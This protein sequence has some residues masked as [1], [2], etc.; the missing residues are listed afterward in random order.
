[1][2]TTIK[3]A[4]LTPT[5]KQKIQSIRDFLNQLPAHWPLGSVVRLLTGSDAVKGAIGVVTGSMPPRYPEMQW[6]YRVAM[7]A[8]WTDHWLD[9]DQLELLERSPEQA[10]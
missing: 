4:E 8:G 6:A 10:N 3:Q 7:L 9:A 2:N 1:M 5:Q